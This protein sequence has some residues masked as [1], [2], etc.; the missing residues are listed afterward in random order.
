MFSAVALLTISIEAA[1]L[2]DARVLADEI[3]TTTTPAQNGASPTWCA[4][5]PLLVRENGNVWTSISVHDPDEPP[6]CNTHWEL[7][8]R[9]AG[10]AWKR[11]RSGH[12]ASEREPCPLFMPEPDKLM[13]SIHPKILEHERQSNGDRI[14]FCEPAIARFDP[15]DLDDKARLLK[16][17][18]AT[19][20]ELNQHSYRS[21]GV[22]ADSG[23]FLMMLIDRENKFHMTRRD[24][25][26]AWHPAAAPE[27]P[28]RSCY[29]N[30]V[31]RGD[32][33]HVFAIGDIIEPNSEWKAEKF[34]VLNR[35]WDYAFRRVFYAR[36]PDLAKGRFDGPLEVDSVEDTAGWAFNLDMLEDAA[37]RVHL[38]WVRQNIQYAFMRDRFFPGTPIVEEVRHAVL[39]AGR[40]VSTETLLRREV[41]G[42]TGG[43]RFSSGRFHQLPDGRL[44]AVLTTDLAD[45][46]E[47]SDR[48]LLLQELDLAARASP[49]P[50]RVQLATAPPRNTFFTN[51]A[52]G[53]SK[54]DN[55]I[56]I[57]TTETKDGVISIRYIH[58][59][60][61]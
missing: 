6:A 40:V 21:V 46:G 32:E 34:R 23:A 2:S 10:S 50:V 45:H 36:A 1:P 5:A 13:L 59:L 61:P 31:L 55:N 18:F 20:P 26:G 60:V 38:L 3:I 44:L 39:E 24:A 15:T 7:W 35:Q 33:A 29:A 11:M 19:R 52:R 54:P 42:S 17:E 58:V 51:T 12:A 41:E 28:I 49:P 25:S 9:P 14:W 56:D 57:L 30:I 4:G 53:G 37:G 48:A 47:Q 27:F 22:D 16:P 43:W 8:R